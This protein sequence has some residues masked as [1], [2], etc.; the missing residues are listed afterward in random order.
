MKGEV[1]LKVK[2]KV[3]GEVN[4]KVK[5]GKKNQKSKIK[6]MYVL[7]ISSSL[8]PSLLLPS[9]SHLILSLCCLLF[10]VSDTCFP[11]SSLSFLFIPSFYTHI[12]SLL[13]SLTLSLHTSLSSLLHILLLIPFTQFTIKKQKKTKKQKRDLRAVLLIKGEK[14]II[15]T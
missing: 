2:G 14:K 12:Y 6:V 4:V 15:L 3:K 10:A 9:S 13:P 5:H 8:F 7:F 1:K 11:L